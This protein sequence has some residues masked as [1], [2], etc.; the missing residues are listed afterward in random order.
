MPVIDLP[1]M[2]NVRMGDLE[3]D[4]EWVGEVGYVRP[5]R[6]LADYPR[7]LV[8]TLDGWAARTPD[9][10][11]FADRGPDGEWRRVSY[12]EAAESSRAIAQYLID[13]GLSAERPI[14]V[15]SSNSV[16]HALLALGAMRAGIPYAPVSPAYSLVA[17][18]FGKLR[19]IFDLLTPGMVFAAEGRPFE[20]ALEAVMKPGI[21][22]VNAR[23]PLPGAVPFGRLLSAQPGPAVA[24]A[25]AAITGDTVAKFLFTSGSTGMPKA[26][27]NTQRMIC[28][29]QV[30]IADALA[31]L[32]E[33]PPVMVDWLPWNH[34]AGGNHNFGIAL[35]NGGTLYIDDGA[36]TPAGI[37][38][39]VRNLEEV[40]PTL[41]FNV[42]KGYEMLA[43]HLGPNERLRQNLFSRVKLLQYA[44][45]GLAQ[46]VWD[47]LEG[48]ARQTT[49]EK[50]MIITGYGST[51]TAPFAFTTTWPVNRPGEVGLPAPGLTI[52]LV[53]DGQKL[54][55]RLKGPSVTPGYW[56]MPDKTAECF[57]EEG[58]YRIGDALKFIDPGDVNQGFLF[59]GRV[60]EDFKLSTGTW[61]NFAGVRGALVR[62]FAPYVRD[63]VLAGLDRNHIGALL[64][65]DPDAARRISPE[66]AQTS[67]AELAASPLLLRV[68]Q[69]RL[70]VLAEQSTGSSNLVARAI[71]LDSPPSL[72]RNEVTDKGSINQRAVLTA[73]AKLA[74]DLYTE[75]PPAHVLVAKRR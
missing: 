15:L 44:G 47:A 51:E 28:C 35:H 11:L 53:P 74:D 37:A 4:L 45:A 1:G 16:E 60:S 67:D 29:N 65:L 59:D 66:L 3:A 7:S 25:N 69:E 13:L 19:H 50:V 40:A 20:A 2:R 73:R 41:Y 5:R 63:A 17:K 70:D 46:H 9:Q 61:V 57:D 32:K 30:M 23:D 49:G 14:V 64:F 58:F 36:P 8:D 21:V 48:F 18:D 26:V 31:F 12:A 56:R 72:D 38:K 62:A 34:T 54:E 39:T 33:E 27:I 24:A 75:P 68:F 71:V 22:L 55:L 42:P 43:A 52:K 6:E 10:I